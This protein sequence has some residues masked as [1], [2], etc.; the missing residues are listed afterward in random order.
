MVSS[1]FTRFYLQIACVLVSQTLLTASDLNRK[2]NKYRFNEYSVYIN[3]YT[4]LTRLLRI[5]L[6]KFEKNLDT[7]CLQVSKRLEI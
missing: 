1:E 2:L 7:G 5:Q 4:F 6:N 3:T